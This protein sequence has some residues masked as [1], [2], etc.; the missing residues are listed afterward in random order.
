MK[1]KLD[2]LVLILFLSTA[3]IILPARKMSIINYEVVPLQLS[4]SLTILVMERTKNSECVC[5]TK[6]QL[7]LSQIKLVSSFIL[8]FCV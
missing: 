8:K 7:K 4:L 3:C 6:K 5:H 2:C 1:I